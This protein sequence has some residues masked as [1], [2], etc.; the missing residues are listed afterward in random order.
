MS[1]CH[2]YEP[3]G[4]K[5]DLQVIGGVRTKP[6]EDNTDKVPRTEVG[7]QSGVAQ[8]ERKKGV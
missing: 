2:K 8:N 1:D 7:I 6:W 5:K 3:N 4:P